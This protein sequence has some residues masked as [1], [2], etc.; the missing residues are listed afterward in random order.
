MQEIHACHIMSISDHSDITPERLTEH[1]TSSFTGRSFLKLLDFSRD[2]ILYLIDLSAK[3]KALK[4]SGVLHR[5]LTGKNIVLIFEKTSTRTRC[6]FE[7]AASDLGM[8]STYLA[9]GSSQLGNKESVADTARVLGSMYDGIEYRGFAQSIVDELA[10]Y[11][12]CPVFNGLTDEFHPT[13]MIADMLTVQECFPEG[14]DGLKLAFF[15]DARNNVANSLMV[16]SAKLGI[17]Y[18][19][20]GP[21][22]RMPDESL[23]ETCRAIAEQNGCTITLTDDVSEAAT[24]ANIIYTDI[25]LSMGEDESL[26]KARIDELCPYRITSDIMEMT[27]ADSIFM[28]CLPSFHNTDTAI[29]AKIAKEFGIDELEVTDEVFESTSSVVFQEAENRLHSIKAIMYATLS[30]EDPISNEEI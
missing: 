11:A 25:W 23:V 9:P 27:A 14:F 13:Q 10:R 21:A 30:T 2:E 22:E 8:G 12:E 17:D 5:Y 26:W 15:G 6:A 4:R 1:M 29:G 16:V 3:F 24:D 7:V 20:C 28:H 18:V 19:A